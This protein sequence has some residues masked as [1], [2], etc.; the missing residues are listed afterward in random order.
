MSFVGSENI[1]DSSLWHDRELG[2]V[3]VAPGLVNQVAGVI[4]TDLSAGR[5]WR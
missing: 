4:Q 2:I 3:L 5:R 1:S